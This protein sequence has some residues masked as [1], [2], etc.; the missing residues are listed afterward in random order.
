MSPWARWMAPAPA[1]RLGWLRALTGAWALAYVLWR[2]SGYLAIGRTDPEHWRPRGLAV[3]LDGPPTPDQVALLVHLAIA[4][5]VLFTLG[6]AHRWLAPITA[7]LL[8]VVLTLRNSWGVL[9]HTDNLLLLHIIVLAITPSA[10]AVSVD[11]RRRGGDAGVGPRWGWPVRLVCAVT[12][13]CYFLAGV[14]KVTA[15]GWL[16]WASGQNLRNQVLYDSLHRELMGGGSI[17]WLPLLY[18]L[19]PLLWIGGTLTIALELLAPALLAWRRTRWPALL[20]LFGM[21]WG[22]RLSMLIYFWYPLTGAAFVSFLPLE[23][24]DAVWARLRGR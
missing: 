6:V 14:A 24:L 20:G 5:L 13:C 15:S 12:A 7:L 1:S 21:H 4:G 10:D 23:R 17:S 3:L 22:I 8:L 2:R 16:G 11:A 9:L 18:D 19:G